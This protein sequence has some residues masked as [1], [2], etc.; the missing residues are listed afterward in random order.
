MSEYVDFHYMPLEGKITGK[1][2]LK[3]TEDAIN[4]LGNKVYNLDIDEERIDEAIEKSEQAIDTANSALSAVTTD[5]SV[6]KNNIAEMKATDIELGVTA[7]T[8]GKNLYNDGDGA[9]YVVRQKKSGDTDGE[10]AVFLDN[11]NVAERLKQFDFIAKGNNIIY[12]ENVDTLRLADAIVGNVYGTIGYYSANDGG[13]SIYAIRSK[14]QDDMDDGGSLIFLDNGNVAELIVINKTVNVKQ[15]GAT[16]DGV[17]DDTVAIQHA[18]NYAESNNA[19]DDFVIYIPSICL[20]ETLTI[21]NTSNRGKLVFDGTGGFL[22]TDTQL[23]QSNS[24]AWYNFVGNIEFRN[25]SFHSEE[26]NGFFV[27]PGYPF[28]DC[29]F[30]NCVF[31]NVDTIVKSSVFIQTIK[32][33]GCTIRGGADS[34]IIGTSGQNIT[35]DRCY[36]TTRT[37]GIAKQIDVESTPYDELRRLRGLQLSVL[38]VNC[39]IFSITANELAYVR[40]TKNVLFLGNVMERVPYLVNAEPAYQPNLASEYV[41]TY[42]VQ[43]INASI[44]NNTISF[45]P[46]SNAMCRLSTDRV[47]AGTTARINYAFSGNNCIDVPLL[48]AT[49]VD[50]TLIFQPENQPVSFQDN[51]IIN[52]STSR[53]IDASNVYNC[54]TGIE[55]ITDSIVNSTRYNNGYVNPWFYSSQTYYGTMYGNRFVYRKGKIN[56]DFPSLSQTFD[57]YIANGADL[58]NLT[59]PGTYVCED[60]TVASSLSNCPYTFSAFKMLVMRITDNY[61]VQTIYSFTD[62]YTRGYNTFTQ[63]WSDWNHNRINHANIAKGT[64]PSQDS[65][66]NIVSLYDNGGNETK[67]TI[68]ESKVVVS[69][70]NAYSI[71]DTVYTPTSNSTSYIQTRLINSNSVKSFQ[72]RPSNTVDLGTSYFTWKDIYASNGTIQTSDERLKDNITQI[73]NEV[74]DAWGEVNWCQFQFKDAIEKKGVAARIHTGAIAQRI[75]DVFEKHN[76]DAFRYGLLCYDEWDAEEDVKAGNKYGLRYEE[77]LCMEAAYQRRRADRLEERIARL[78][79]LLDVEGATE[80]DKVV[81]EPTERSEEDTEDR[82]E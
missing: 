68:A 19:N 40:F 82:A 45:H 30:D 36:I 60:S 55:I 51:S 80:D 2:V 79:A 77:A 18:I 39:G 31:E 41:A 3:Q 48:D 37:G 34:L 62:E 75:K 17:T 16:G 33:T 15:F 14:T 35:L 67:N 43:V 74:L 47:K 73:P 65:Y 53:A 63:S 71:D 8:R 58:N 57:V 56:A 21:S 38:V 23:F 12:V 49:D 70:A 25:I 44:T 28:I 69:S 52:G 1:Q 76:L 32:I 78:E 5:R 7:A 66:Y 9:F 26:S 13:S 81:V 64:A 20:T 22:C 6:W 29:T 61:I 27:M 59:T 4:D 46:N 11:G 72:A 54:A 10:D 50:V 42:G 24:D